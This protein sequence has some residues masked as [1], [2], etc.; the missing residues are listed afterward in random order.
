MGYITARELAAQGYHTIFT[1]RDT[2]KGRTA[3][4]S[5]QANNPAGSFE[6]RQMD[7]ADLS[8]VKD[9]GKA[10]CDDGQRLDVLVNNAGVMACPEQATRD[11]FE[12]Q[13]GVNHLGHFTLTAGVWPL[14]CQPERCGV[15]LPAHSHERLL[16]GSVR[17]SLAHSSTCT[18]V[19][20]TVRTCVCLQTSMI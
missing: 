5:L 14:L 12:Y 6:V 2:E 4:Q 1:S 9:L 18:T 16:E 3:L 8:T 10:L 11:G 19:T 15:N 7:L 13:L 20:P 17:C